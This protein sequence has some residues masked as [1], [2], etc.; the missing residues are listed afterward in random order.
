MD[1]SKQSKAKKKEGVKYDIPA[2]INVNGLFLYQRRTYSM[3][4]SG[5]PMSILMITASKNIGKPYKNRKGIVITSRVHPGETN[6]S[7][8]FQ[9]I[10]EKLTGNDSHV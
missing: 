2:N 9:G 6:A 7:F 3:T 8:V 5:L 4:L 10:L 1:Q